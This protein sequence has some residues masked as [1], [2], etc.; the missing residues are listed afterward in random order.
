MKS[1][2][3]KLGCLLL[4]YL[5]IGGCGNVEPNTF[6]LTGNIQGNYSGYIYL[7]FDSV[8]DSF[9]VK[10]NKF[11]FRGEIFSTTSAI[12]STK[13]RTSAM[14][15]DFYLEQGEIT[16]EIEIQRKKVRE[17]ELDWII[18]KSIEGSK[19]A[20]LQK[21]FE[22]YKTKFEKSKNWHAK[23]YLKI[24]EIITENPQSKY[25]GSLLAGELWDSVADFSK[26]K[27][28]YAKLDIVYQDSL[29]VNVLKTN[30]FPKE[31]SL[32][33]KHILDFELKSENGNLINTKNYRGKLL[34][35]DFWA[36]WCMPCR[37]QMPDI[38]EIYNQYKEQDFRILA[39][40]LDSEKDRQKWLSAI[41][42]ENATWD[43]V[44][45][46]GE[47]SGKVAKMYNIQS[48][49][50]NFLIDEQGIIINENISP[51][52]LEEHLNRYFKT[53]N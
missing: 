20:L 29:T 52:Q 11:K 22:N 13:K 45:E 44:L 31:T 36:S 17:T 34:F 19:T 6:V 10:N 21:E 5:F 47:F 14:D 50:S 51:K 35:V 16:I 49:P 15:K 41:K 12:L 42:K 27:K 33:G 4:L 2:C 28:M 3:L 40:S 23:K 18:I 48:I 24:D 32:V 38:V 53:K 7:S 8:K 1:Y 26:L 9:L 25:S 37:K 46:T 43:N 39:V 30:L